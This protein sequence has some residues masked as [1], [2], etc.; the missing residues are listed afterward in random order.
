MAHVH[1]VA[2][3]DDYLLQE[4]LDRLLDEVRSGLGGVEPELLSDEAA[5]EAVALEL[6]S[7]SLFTPQRLLVVSDVTAWITRAGG[8]AGKKKAAESEAAVDLSAL[9]GILEEG[10]SDQMGL[11]MAAVSATAPKGP[12]VDAVKAC[13]TLHWLPLPPPPKPWDEVPVS[14]EQAAVLRDVIRHAAGEVRFARAAERLLFD[15][16]GFSPRLLAS[17]AR[18]LAAAAAGGEVG[19]ELVRQLCFP[20]QRSL[21][22][23]RDAVLERRPEPLLDLLLAAEAGQ[24]VR[25]FQ[26]RQ[27]DGKG[28]AFS[29]VAQAWSIF[30]QL[31]YLR[32]LAVR[33]GL[34]DEMDPERTNVE[35]WYPRRF[36]DGIAPR[37]KELLE[38]DAPSPVV[39]T[40]RRTPHPFALGHLFRA[41]GRYS[42]EELADALADLG[43]VEA[44]LR[45]DRSQ[46]VVSAYFARVLP[47]SEP[48]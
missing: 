21:E 45:G 20:K 24:V 7:P 27:L 5:P 37:L 11:V 6:S 16:L 40:G 44:A 34:L 22:T 33:S 19:E 17:E 26:G 10:L 9:T 35:R 3:P 43:A 18:K 39:Q 29:L 1:L 48:V 23:A 8:R 32:R 4:R 14:L 46:E 13:G 38:E 31:F 41:A 30:Q 36:K 15:R 47:P 12:L 28:A 2:S 25:D 42:D